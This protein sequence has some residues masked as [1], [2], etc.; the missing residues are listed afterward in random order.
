MDDRND[1]T[2][3]GSKAVMQA[4]EG[5]LIPSSPLS[6]TFFPATFELLKA[7][8]KRITIEPGQQFTIGATT[9]S[10]ISL[11]HPGG[12]VGFRFDLQGRSFVFCTDHEH[13]DAPDQALADFARGADL[14]YLDGQYLAAEYEGRTGIMGETPLARR[15]WG[16]SSV[17]ACAAT[18]A[19]AGVRQLH[20]GHREPKRDDQ[21]LAKFEA[22]L[23]QCLAEALRRAGKDAS[24][25]VG[26]LA[27]E[28]MTVD[29]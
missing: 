23:Q 2:L 29:L 24:A 4:L 8:R 26:C 19:A 13:L 28:G 12:C 27:R 15:G 25:C 6:K 18:A 10:T 3:Y 17:E 9:V 11:R 14:L 7:L 20:I 1:F 16:H 5:M 22:Y 21:D